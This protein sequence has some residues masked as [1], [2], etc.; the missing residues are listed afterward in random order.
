MHRSHVTASMIGISNITMAS[1]NSLRTE[2]VGMKLLLKRLSF[3]LS[4]SSLISH[5][6]D[7][8]SIVTLL[9]DDLERNLVKIY[10]LDTNPNNFLNPFPCRS[11]TFGLTVIAYWS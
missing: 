10:T 3:R 7:W 8:K 6:S 1:W 4:V 9:Y 5:D 2:L 11:I